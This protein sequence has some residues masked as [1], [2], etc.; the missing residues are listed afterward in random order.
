MT[1]LQVINTIQ[2]ISSVQPN[3]HS[4][5]GEF[6]A[7]NDVTAKYS[8]IILQQRTHRRNNDFMIYSF[9]LGYADR[10]NEDKSNE[11]EVQSTAIQVID[12]IVY[13]LENLNF[14][15]TVGVYNT[16]TQ[17]FL[18]EAAG[19]YVE[20]DIVVPM[21]ECEDDFAEEKLDT[22]IT[23]NGEYNFIPKGLG[24]Q[25]VHLNVDVAKL[26]DKSLDITKNGNYKVQYDK[27]FSGLKTVDVNVNVPDAEIH[28][29]T[30]EELITINNK[31]YTYTP[32]KDYTGIGKLN[33]MVQIPEQPIYEEGYVVGKEDGINE[34]KRKLTDINITQN[35]TYTKE[36]GYKNVVVNVPVPVINN[37]EKSITITE[38]GQ[39]DITPDTNYTG[40]S[41]V[42]V[43]VNINTQSYYDNGYSQGKIDGKTEGIAEQKAKL[44]D[45]SITENGTYEKEDGYKSVVV[46][47]PSD[48]K[49]ETELTKTLTANDTYTYTPDEGTVYNKVI[50]TTDIHPTE[51]L[52]RTYVENGQ[53]LIDGEYKDG[54]INVNVPIPE[55]NNQEKSITINSNGT[56]S[57]VPDNGYTGISKMNITVNVPTSGGDGIDLTPLGYTAQE[58]T[59]INTDIQ[60]SIAYS[61][62]LLESYTD[63]TSYSNNYRITF[64]PLFPCSERTNFYGMFCYCINL[65][66]IPTLDTT[67]GTNFSRMF[68]GCC[69]LKFVSQFDTSKNTDFSYLFRDC[70]SLTSIPALDT[71]KG[72]DFQYMFSNCYMLSSIPYLDTSNTSSNITDFSFMF[73][74]CR[75]LSTIPEIDVSK[76]YTFERMFCGCNSL[77]N[78]GKLHTIMGSNFTCMFCGCHKL[79]TISLINISNTDDKINLLDMFEGCSKLKNITFEGSINADIS[80]Y[81]TKILTYNSIKSIL[82][83]CAATTNT[84]AKTIVFNQSIKDQNNELTNLVASC[85][86]KGWTVSGLTITTA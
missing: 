62:S 58:N 18:A 10:L 21:G 15:C 52:E 60:D 55:I 38:N 63:S 1:L 7:L 70:N 43:N 48:K 42:G 41:K 45:I 77:V 59:I 36:D 72:S 83:A 23:A 78:I 47:V 50:I 20:L 66:S 85:T 64:V 11:V 19:G 27:G 57:V 35:G 73:N 37:Q 74:G 12:D 54:V 22:T 2:K 14:D 39:T 51:R 24:F 6:L 84:N 30:K 33:V 61:Q 75:S 65:I 67:S 16:F 5:V 40:L 26:Q 71:K 17:R 8:A 82:T 49:P 80:F 81:Y 46:N 32:D 25:S 13:K 56:S 9:Y 31:R 69:S 79:E 34:Q 4:F 53:Y 28:N 76:G 29:Q 68:D 3:I 44:T 86:S